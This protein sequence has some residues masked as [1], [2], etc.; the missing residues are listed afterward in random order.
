MPAPELWGVVAGGAAAVFLP[1]P[2]PRE[3]KIALW[4]PDGTG[5]PGAAD[6]LTV[7]RAHGSG[8]RSR[9]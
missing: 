6:E 4:T 1:A 9:R 7:V 8:V 5:P 2:L 3:G